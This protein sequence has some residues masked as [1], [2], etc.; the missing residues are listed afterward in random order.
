MASRFDI[1]LNNFRRRDNIRDFIDALHD[2]ECW[3]YPNGE[4]FSE[5]AHCDCCGDPWAV[6]VQ[7]RE[8][9]A[10]ELMH[11]FLT[12]VICYHPFAPFNRKTQHEA[13]LA[14]V[15]IDLCPEEGP[16]AYT[17]HYEAADK[18][19]RVATEKLDLHQVATLRSAFMHRYE[20]VVNKM[21]SVNADRH[22][23]VERAIAGL[24]SD[25]EMDDGSGQNET[26]LSEEE[27]H[28]CDVSTSEKSGCATILTL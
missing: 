28:V 23:A 13:E 9:K 26:P 19:E 5:A 25:E 6:D 1:I 8:D 16:G 18:S 17:I 2:S 22:D 20:W 4:E 24:E 3:P 12:N 27:D 14:D 7:L 15:S 11:L 21:H 10:H